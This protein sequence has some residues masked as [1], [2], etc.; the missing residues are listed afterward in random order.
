MK[1]KYF[2]LLYHSLLLIYVKANES[3]EDTKQLRVTEESKKNM[4]VDCYYTYWPDG[5]PIL[6]GAAQTKTN[7]RCSGDNVV[8]F[9]RGGDG[10]WR[11]GGRWAKGWWG[12][13]GKAGGGVG[14]GGSGRKKGDRGGRSQN[15][16]PV[17]KGAVETSWN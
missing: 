14:K 3:S 1:I 4:G 9:P 6:K 2:I 5:G 12:V 15:F 11:G 7:D 17:E 16:P 13:S 8:N 10:K